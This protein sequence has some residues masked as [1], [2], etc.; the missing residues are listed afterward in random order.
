MRPPF[1]DRLLTV[2]RI[3]AILALALGGAL[4][5]VLV[6]EL[7]APL[8][9]GSHHDFLAFYG[10]GRLILAG[11]PGGIYDAAKLTAIQRTIVPG[12]VGMNGYMPFINPPFAAVAFAPLAALPAEAARAVWA[13]LS[14]VLLG[15]A[16]VAIAWQPSATPS[17]T[18]ERWLIAVL[19]AL[20]FPAY[21]A[22]AEGQ[23]S[24]LLLAAGIGAL[25]AARRGR[26]GLAGLVLVPFWLKPQLIVLPLLALV[27][28]RRW[29]AVA[30]ACGGGSALVVLSV[31]FTGIAPFARY[32]GYL[33]AVVT[34]HFTGAGA[35]Q[36]TTWQGDLKSTEG[37]NGLLV[38][39]LG[40]G[41][42]GI[43]NVLWL[44]GVGAL[45]VLYGLAALRRRPGFATPA[46]RGMLA[47]GILVTLLVNP[48]LFAQDCALVFLALAALWPLPSPLVLPA[49]AG[50]VGLAD[51]IALDQGTVTLHLFTIGLVALVVLVSVRA[52]LLAPSQAL[53]SRGG[54]G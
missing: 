31:P 25:A 8:R 54:A 30:A 23:W 39:Y 15:A 53:G 37:L 27:L 29:R 38:G 17:S 6:L 21:H 4:A 51:L 26:W 13:T 34:S 43:V 50:A 1:G 3:V 12:P 47:A 19:I 2:G 10:A 36:T 18:R 52:V 49:T 28:A 46:A 22:L 7:A 48:N 40:Q 41:S 14:V 44:L 9:D 42:T 35:I 33:A 32:I 5:V 45:I 20:S 11:D 24:I 16:A